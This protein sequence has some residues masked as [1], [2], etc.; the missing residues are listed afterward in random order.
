MAR[1]VDGLDQAVAGDQFVVAQMVRQDAVFQRSEH[2]RLH[3]Q[4]EQH[5]QQAGHAV[6]EE[7]AGGSPISSDL[8]RLGCLDQPRFVETI[9]QLAGGRGQQGVR[10][11]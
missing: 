2:R 10:A 1:K 11:R 8:G 7:R 3:A 5:G 6:G 9:R 4:A